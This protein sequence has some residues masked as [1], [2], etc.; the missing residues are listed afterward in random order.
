MLN[1]ARH[2]TVKSI[3]KIVFAIEC[4]TFASLEKIWVK[5]GLLTKAKYIFL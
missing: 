3:M 2:R 1:K 5:P 4:E